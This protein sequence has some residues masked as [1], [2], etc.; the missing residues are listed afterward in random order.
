M[1]NKHTK[2][3]VDLET[4]KLVSEIAE[5][6]SRTIGG[7]VKHWA[8]QDAKRLKVGEQTVTKPKIPT[9]NTKPEVTT[10]APNKMD[11]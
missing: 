5:R 7:Q 8:R 9:A 2:I 10:N 6:E 3:S 1:T 11:T 4:H